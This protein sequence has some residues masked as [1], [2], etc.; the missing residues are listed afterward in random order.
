M[1]WAFLWENFLKSLIASRWLKRGNGQ[2]GQAPCE[3]RLAIAYAFMELRLLLFDETNA[4]DLP[5]C[6]LFADIEFGE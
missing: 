2:L 4:N 1:E 5:S 3:M 6:V